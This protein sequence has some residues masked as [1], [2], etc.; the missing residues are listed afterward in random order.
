MMK[1]PNNK[2]DRLPFADPIGVLTEKFQI[3]IVKALG[4]EFADTDPVIRKSQNKQFGDFQ[5]NAA[6][7]LA[8]KV[9]NGKSPR[10]IAVEILQYL[11]IDDMCEE[12]TVAGP[13]FINLKFKPGALNSMLEVMDCDSLGVEPIF[14]D[15]A[16]KKVV[17]DMVSVNI[18][19]SMHVG[20]LRSSIIGDS[21]CRILERLGFEP[22]PQN[23]LGDWGLQIAMVLSY[24]IRSK[25]DFD[26]LDVAQLEEAYRSANLSCKSDVKALET[27]KRI[28]A[29]EHRI[30]E[31]EEQIAGAEEEMAAAKETL[32]KLQGGDA[33]LVEAWHKIT[34][35]TLKECYKICELLDLRLN[36]EHERGESFYRDRLG[37]VVDDLLQAGVAE[38]S[39]GAIIVRIPDEETPL[40]IRKSDGGYLY[41]TTDLAGIR[42]R[43]GELGATRL[44]YVVDA[45]QR[46]HFKK[47]FAV[48]GMMGWDKLEGGETATLV[49]VPFGAVCGADGKPLKTRSG[50]NIK[51]IDL[52]AEAI[53]RA[54]KIVEEKNPDLSASEKVEV[55][56][57][58]GIGC[59][60]YADL[61][62]QLS[63]DYVFDWD[64]MLA[65]EGN[66]GAYLQNQYVR[67]RSIGRKAVTGDNVANN[68]VENS[69]FM[70]VEEQEKDL[71]LVL[72][73][74]PAM[75]M[76]VAETLETNRLCQ[77][78]YDLAQAFSSFYTYC[79]VLKAESEGLIKARL[80][81][82]SLTERVLAD[83]LHLLGI[84][85]LERM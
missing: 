84:R 48:A 77:Y 56:R 82:C 69:A 35:I 40:I 79:P 83:G 26:K 13:G 32:V 28:N 12:P 20:H 17:I 23:H 44:I 52:L 29:G 11:N 57:A 1:N 70:I 63:K 72:L 21:F 76:G 85:T 80:R 53:S 18:A 27:A 58:V 54:G 38:E 42:Y 68:N 8:K 73:R 55:A 2:Y 36:E 33:G 45:R 60:K 39:E 43:V 62:T 7:G 50:D 41:A 67:I 49:H 64:R 19:K 16:H 51:L 66:T 25:V 3:A 5:S 10:D 71:A 65:F 78:L 9:S 31:W 47:V 22:L 15:A 37:S 6:M 59:I 46:D 74:Y 75:L 14:Q 4:T 34:R 81:L 30:V 61:S 24:L